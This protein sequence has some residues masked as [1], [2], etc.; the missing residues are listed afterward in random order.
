MKRDIAYAPSPSLDAYND[1]NN[2]TLDIHLV[3]YVFL[4]AD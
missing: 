4:L 1:N 3:I 2:N